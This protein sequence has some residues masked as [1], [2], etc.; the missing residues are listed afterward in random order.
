MSDLREHDAELAELF[1]QSKREETWQEE[2]HA[3][4]AIWLRARADELMSGEIQS[5]QRRARP[6]ML[7]WLIAAVSVM[8]AVVLGL[9]QFVQTLPQQSPELQ[10]MFA[11]L[12]FSPLSAALLALAAVPALG[13]LQFFWKETIRR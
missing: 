6:L 12:A 13:L 8:A 5:R 11:G 9:F 7:G 2:P 1:A 3:A 10:E 4:A